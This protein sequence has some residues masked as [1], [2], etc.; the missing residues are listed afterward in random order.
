MLHPRPL[1]CRRRG[2]AAWRHTAECVPRK[3]RPAVPCGAARGTRRGA[4]AFPRPGAHLLLIRTRV[5][6]VNLRPLEPARKIDVNDL[7][8]GVEIV[9][10]P[11][12]FAVA[13]PGLLD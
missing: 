3:G 5:V 13:V 4:R 8:L 2:A 7:R 12:A 9:D 11:T 10:F 1:G 6:R